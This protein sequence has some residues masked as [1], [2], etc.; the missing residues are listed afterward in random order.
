MFISILCDDNSFV[1]IMFRM[2]VRENVVGKMKDVQYE[3]NG[4]GNRRERER[5]RERSTRHAV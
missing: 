4:D 2:M 5:E 1:R 3:D